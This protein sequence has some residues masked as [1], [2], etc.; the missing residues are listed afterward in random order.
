VLEAVLRSVDVEEA[1][2]VA[3]ADETFRGAAYGVG[4]ERLQAFLKSRGGEIQQLREAID[5]G[6]PTRLHPAGD[7]LTSLGLGV[8]TVVPFPGPRGIPAGAVILVGIVPDVVLKRVRDLADEAGPHLARIAEVDVLRAQVHRLEKDLSLLDAMVNSFS[9]PVVLT[10]RE[11]NFLFANRRAEELFSSRLDESEGRRRAIRVNDLMFSSF[12]TQAVIGGAVAVNREL[13]LVDPND[14]SDLLF[15]VMTVPLPPALRREGVAISVLRDIT[16][17]KRALTE[18]G[19]Q[20]SRSRVAERSARQESDRLS[21]MLANM[22]D[23]LLV[24]DEA[25]NIILM[26]SRA[27]R[28]FESDPERDEQFVRIVQANDTKFTTMISDFLLQTGDRRV[29]NLILQ[30]PESSEELPVEVVSSKIVDQRG[31]VTAIVSVLHDLSAVVE[32]ERLARE[33]Q[34]LNEGL[35][36]RIRLA[37]EEL[38]ER[39]RRLEFQSRELQK[40]SRLKSEF[41][42]SMSHELRTPINAMLGYTALLREEIYGALNEKQGSALRKI[43]GASQHLLAL[44]NDILDLSKI[45]AGKMPVR[46]EAVRLE[47][48]VLEL[49]QTIE[50]MVREK[51]LDYRTEVSEDLPAMETDRTKVKQILLNL[52]SNA[53]KFTSEGSVVVRAFT[54]H[55][56]RTVRIEVQDTGIGIKREDQ[57]TIFD[58]FRQVDQSSTRKYGGT[59]LGLSIT[60]KLARLMGGAV[61]VESEFGKGSTFR[62]D[63]PAGL[64]TPSTPPSEDLDLPD[65]DVAGM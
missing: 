49:S 53:V 54:V 28:L 51:K 40:A 48:V 31:Q 56:G 61:Q 13:N 42:A 32:N 24:T 2:V 11:N 26:N 22:G 4:D 20:F 35:E 63:L 18:L 62:V 37:T 50:P 44:I 46:I 29:E 17:L 7:D 33:L 57:E 60:R 41:L 65:A 16:D 19:V 6:S 47:T 39:N 38:E 43:Y 8:A 5:S 64:A 27:E 21:V 36:E 9:D 1:A 14:G 45:E 58:D 55:G 52:L 30:D 12:L 34:V 25:S 23:P 59:G 3:L 15:E 10:D